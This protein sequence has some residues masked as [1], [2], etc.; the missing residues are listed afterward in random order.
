MGGGVEGGPIA[1]WDKRKKILK[2]NKQGNGGKWW[3][4]SNNESPQCVT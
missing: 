4:K 2:G 1:E 3:R